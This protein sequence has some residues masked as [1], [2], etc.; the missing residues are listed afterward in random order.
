[1]RTDSAKTIVRL[2]F[3]YFSFI[4]L[5]IFFLFTG[6]LRDDDHPNCIIWLSQTIACAA[7]LK[8]G[9]KLCYTNITNNEMIQK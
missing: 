6:L 4:P 2:F 9:I 3:A 8:Y 5:I 1:M 7:N